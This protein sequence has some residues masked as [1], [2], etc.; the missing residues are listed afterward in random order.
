MEAK[1]F[2]TSG[3]RDR[4]G[5]WRAHPE[6]VM[7]L[8]ACLAT[9]LNNSGIVVVGRD[10]RTSSEVFENA[11][12]SGLLSGGCCVLKA[13]IV[14]TPV[15]A[16]SVGVFK[17]SAGVMI[18]ASHNPPE[19]N[20]LKFWSEEGI[21]F[22]PSQELELERIFQ[23]GAKLVEWYE[24]KWASEVD[25]IPL[26]IEKILKTVQLFEKHRVVVDCGNGATSVVTPYL[27]KLLGCEV[28]TLNSDVS[29]VPSRNP[30]PTPDNLT[31][32]SR[33]VRESEA[34]IGIAHDGDGDRIVAL[35]EN[36]NFVDG[37]ALLAIV[38]GYH[39]KSGAKIVTT[40]DASKT[41]EDVV[42][43]RGGE[44]IRTKVGDVNVALACKQHNA[45]F[46]G[47]P[48]GA[49][50][51]PNVHMAPDGP[52]GAAILLKI[53]EEEDERLSELVGR[54]PKYV[55]KRAKIVCEES[56]KSLLLERFLKTAEEMGKVETVDG[57][58]VSSDDGW[59]LVR[60]SGTEPVIR[61]TVEG[62]DEEW[63]DGMI[64]KVKSILTEK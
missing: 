28:I 49:W 12:I 1:L 42:K 4:W 17:A 26:Y 25:V 6:T 47:E 54:L 60:A 30:E 19:Y 40:I 39:A 58:R 57:I 64:K 8:G 51:L 59:V 7:K 14:P 46:G 22:S 34:T 48:C 24:V 43:S 35:D 15:L 2:G 38:A 27:L 3:I 44:I 50:V 41:I 45:V 56:R 10:A 31:E 33:V 11:V 37:D 23:Q 20:G 61:I 9:Y 16:F 32:L 13:G 53:L 55:L 29:G 18:T 36:G 5:N 21:G 62:K 52:L 63:V